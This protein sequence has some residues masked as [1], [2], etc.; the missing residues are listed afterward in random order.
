MKRDPNYPGY[1]FGWIVVAF[2]CFC[3]FVLAGALIDVMGIGR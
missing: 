1:R 2:I 3:L